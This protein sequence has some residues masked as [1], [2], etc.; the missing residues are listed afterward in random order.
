[1]LKFAK[2]FYV[3]WDEQVVFSLWFMNHPG[4]SGMKPT[5]YW[6]CWSAFPLLGQIPDTYHL[7]EGRFS[8]RSFSSSLHIVLKQKQHGKATVEYF[9]SLVQSPLSW[10]QGRSS[11]VERSGKWENYNSYRGDQKKKDKEVLGKKMHPSGSC[12]QRP[13]SSREALSFC[14]VLSCWLSL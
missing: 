11:I 14:S 7:K 13:A 12:A 10:I 6:L 9:E 3:S 1:M 2:D 5:W 8:F 4:I